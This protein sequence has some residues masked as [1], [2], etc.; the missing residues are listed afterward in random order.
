[1]DENLK[2]YKFLDL[3]HAEQVLEYIAN[4]VGWHVQPNDHL[5]FPGVCRLLNADD[6]DTC[7][8]FRLWYHTV[9]RRYYYNAG[10]YKDGFKEE[11][12]V[13]NKC[14]IG[15]MINKMLEFDKI[16][17]QYELEERKQAISDAA[18]LYEV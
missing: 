8:E 2:L 1:M 5:H 16:A 14:T 15:N 12:I 18:Q 13:C 6:D 11:A 4:R 3:E 10:V 9:H 17:K 7:L